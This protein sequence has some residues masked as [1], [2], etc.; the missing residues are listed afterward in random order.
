MFLFTNGADGKCC[1]HLHV[2]DLPW[3]VFSH[4]WTHLPCFTAI[5]DL[6][7]DGSQ[8]VCLRLQASLMGSQFQTSLIAMQ[9]AGRYEIGGC[10]GVLLNMC[11]DCSWH[12]CIFSPIGNGSI[13]ILEFISTLRGARQAPVFVD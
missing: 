12:L 10:H 2:C 3:R 4:E 1:S 11:L 5:Q 13:N 6:K 7:G 8:R 9:A